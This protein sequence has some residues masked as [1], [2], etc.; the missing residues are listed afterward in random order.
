VFLSL[1]FRIA[2]RAALVAPPPLGPPLF[3]VEGLDLDQERFQRVPA[4][5]ERS[6]ALVLRDR[7]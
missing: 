4:L 7:E 1:P 3:V 6:E 2:R 5:Q